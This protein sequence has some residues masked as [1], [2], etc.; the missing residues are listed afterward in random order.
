MQQCLHFAVT[1]LFAKLLTN[2]VRAFVVYVFS[3]NFGWLYWRISLSAV[4]VYEKSKLKTE[5]NETFPR[6][7]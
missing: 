4:D 1:F 3:E 6:P 2:V 5:M 7:P